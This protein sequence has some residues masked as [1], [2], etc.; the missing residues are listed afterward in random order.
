[1]TIQLTCASSNQDAQVQPIYL[2]PQGTG[3]IDSRNYPGIQVQQD[4][5]C[6]IMLP[7]ARLL[8]NNDLISPFRG[9]NCG[10][11][12]RSRNWGISGFRTRS[13][14]RFFNVQDTTERKTLPTMTKN[15]TSGPYG[16]QSRIVR[17]T[18]QF[19]TLKRS[20]EWNKRD[21]LSSKRKYENLM[22]IPTLAS[23]QSKLVLA[24]DRIQ[25]QI[26]GQRGRSRSQ[27][28]P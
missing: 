26:Q 10:T 24:I 11:L 15:S 5:N 12:L 3:I 8:F 1:M 13:S 4:P 16:L 18:E 25:G 21:E 7:N 2:F 28:S 14:L 20:K 19:L 9:W 27:H 22:A 6:A 17:N 23:L